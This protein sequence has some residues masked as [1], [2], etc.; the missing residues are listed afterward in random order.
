MN[1]LYIE[2]S[3]NTTESDWECSEWMEIC[4]HNSFFFNAPA[5]KS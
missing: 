3:A 1:I 4:R 2:G 5:L